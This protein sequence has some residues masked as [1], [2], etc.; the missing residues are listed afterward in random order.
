MATKA[1]LFNA[2]LTSQRASGVTLSGGKAYFYVPGSVTLKAIYEDRDKQ[3]PAANPVTLDSNGQALVFGDGIYDVQVTN[4]AGSVSLPLWEDVSI[5]DISTGNDSVANYDSL[6]AAVSAIGATE[7]TLAVTADQAVT[8]NLTIPATLHLVVTDSAVISVASGKT[9][10]INSPFNAPITQVFSGPG[11]V[12]LSNV[13]CVYPEWWGALGGTNN[14]T[15]AI[16]A[17][18][19]SQPNESLSGPEVRFTKT[20][21][22]ATSLILRGKTRYIGSNTTL[23]AL[24]SAELGFLKLDNG[25]VVSIIVDGINLEGGT[26]NAGQHGLYL[27]AD[28]THALNTG[29]IWFSTF[30]NM[31]IQGFAGNQIHSDAQDKNFAGNDVANQF[32]TFTNVRAIANATTTSRALYVIGQ[33]GQIQFNN[34]EFDGLSTGVASTKNVEFDL[35][36]PP[37]ANGSDETYSVDFNTCTFQGA[38]TA[39]DGLYVHGLNFN[40]CHFEQLIKPMI[41]ENSQVN[42]DKCFFVFATAA[43][44]IVSVQQTALT[45]TNNNY[46]GLSGPLIVA[47]SSPNIVAFGN[48]SKIIP[49]AIADYDEFSS[50]LSFQTAVAVD[51]SLLLQGAKCALVAGGN[52]LKNIYST[53]GEGESVAIKALTVPIVI[54]NTGNIVVPASYGATLT[55]AV[56]DTAILVKNDIVGKWWVAGVA[57]TPNVIYNMT[58]YADNAAA[59]AGGLVQGQQYRTSSG[60]LMVVY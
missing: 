38:E 41:F 36:S 35:T 23:N 16:Q 22:S 11:S 46:A 47:T 43:D 8:E 2:L 28:G 48:A 1:Q 26:V 58:A 9:L 25:P 6:A 12:V 31:L 45:F 39:V 17:A 30:A 20:S 27:Y 37:S 3:T 54:D 44:Y 14:D 51:N 59:L 21:Y 4:A 60:I 24:A 19:D 18:I 53:L 42:I 15:V 55:L 52:I 7:T 57:Q 50:G 5:V 40:G 29:G 56:G 49:T 32:L 33:F 10:T 13:A 34:C